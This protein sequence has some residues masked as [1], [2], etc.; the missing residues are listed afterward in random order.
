[1]SSCD[2]QREILLWKYINR[3]RV[4]ADISI[5]LSYLDVPNLLKIFHCV[6]IYINLYRQY[7]QFHRLISADTDIFINCC[8]YGD[9]LIWGLCKKPKMVP[10]TMQVNNQQ[11]MFKWEYSWAA[12]GDG[13]ISEV[14]TVVHLQRLSK[15]LIIA[16][17]HEMHS[18]SDLFCSR[19][20]GQPCPLPD[21][22]TDFA[23][24]FWTDFPNSLSVNLKWCSHT[25]A[26]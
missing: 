24:L 22:V 17:S 18:A 3:D 13:S 8:C 2:V 9:T 6:G 25:V 14:Y 10:I 12:W 1:M 23:C 16:V 19:P 21:V 11:C 15:W 5:S 4:Q 7:N 20:L 26:A